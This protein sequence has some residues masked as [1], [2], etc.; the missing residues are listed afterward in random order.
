MMLRRLAVV[1]FAGVLAA[2][3]NKGPLYLPPA[4]KAQVQPRIPAPPP[5]TTPDSIP[6]RR[7]VPSEALPPPK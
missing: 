1:G 3:G 7:P 5:E 2:C 4:T 6:Q